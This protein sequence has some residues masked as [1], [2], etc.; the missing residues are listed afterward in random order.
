MIE[1]IDYTM[2]PNYLENKEGYLK[3]Y[4]RQYVRT[5]HAKAKNRKFYEEHTDERREATKRCYEKNKEARKA[6]MREY[7]RLRRQSQKI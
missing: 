4:L 6:Q 2:L 3:E 1:G 5:D 7:A